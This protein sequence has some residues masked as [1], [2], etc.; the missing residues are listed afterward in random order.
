VRF[1]QIKTERL[2]RLVERLQ[3]R[4]DALEGAKERTDEQ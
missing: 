1:L 2:E 4:L 3:R